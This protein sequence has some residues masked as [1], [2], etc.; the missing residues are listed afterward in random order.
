MLLTLGWCFFGCGESDPQFDYL[1]N[2]GEEESELLLPRA[3]T[4]HF[5]HDPSILSNQPKT[6]IVKRGDAIEPA[7]QQSPQ[8]AGQP[9]GGTVPAMPPAS[10]IGEA[11]GNVGK[12]F[13]S[14]LVSGQAPA[15]AS[16]GS[17][18]PA[19]NPVSSTSGGGL[20]AADGA[21]IEKLIQQID[22]AIASRDLSSLAALHS[23]TEQSLARQHYALLSDMADA[24][25]ALGETVET[26]QA[27]AKA[28]VDAV[29]VEF[30]K[31]QLSAPIGE[32]A[33]QGPDSAVAGSVRFARDAS[34]WKI[35]QGP[36]YQARVDQIR[37]KAT[38]VQNEVDGL[39]D[40]VLDASMTADAAI[41]Q[42]KQLLA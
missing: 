6:T 30:L 38:T 37:L 13:L 31:A 22:A 2:L 40:K 20:S 14:N 28:K 5:A 23:S 33:M 27:G 34:G 19:S 15:G 25:D 7:P 24:L 16:P 29:I 8:A 26:K 4:V 36:S 10:S 3:S 9:A 41:E 35:E 18:A 1:T 11:F 12:A 21:A 32:L 42:A 39:I 17:S